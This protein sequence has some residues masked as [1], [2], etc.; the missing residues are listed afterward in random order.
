MLLSEGSL[1]LFLFKNP[2]YLDGWLGRCRRIP[3]ILSLPWRV[4]GHNLTFAC[5]LSYSKVSIFANIM[6]SGLPRN[7]ERRPCMSST[8]QASGSLPIH[9]D[10]TINSLSKYNKKHFDRLCQESHFRALD[11]TGHSLV[12]RAVDLDFWG[13][14]PLVRY[15]QSINFLYI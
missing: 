14:L 8:N 11:V 7:L 5:F 1:Q 4:F 6:E 13:L 2:D 9:K 12:V 10:N 15:S 3:H